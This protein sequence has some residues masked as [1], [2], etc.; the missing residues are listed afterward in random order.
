MDRCRRQPI[1]LPGDILEMD[2]KEQDAS[3]ICDRFARDLFVES[4]AGAGDASF[5]FLSRWPLIRAISMDSS[6]LFIDKP[7]GICR[8][9]NNS[10][11][12]MSLLPRSH[13]DL[14]GLARLFVGGCG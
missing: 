8:H 12:F 7:V 3:S 10:P 9:S 11:P 14:N 2:L 1:V 5:F 4:Q 6:D 13:L